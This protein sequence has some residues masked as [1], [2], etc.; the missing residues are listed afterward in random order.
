MTS[1]TSL[2]TDFA[3]AKGI[4]APLL[5][6]TQEVTVNDLPVS[7]VFEGIGEV[8]DLVFYTPLGKIPDE[9]AAQAHR[10]MLE[11]NHLWA[12]TGGAT[13]GLL[14]DGTATLC[15]RTPL[16][17]MNAEVLADTLALFAGQAEN[18]MLLLGTPGAL[19][20]SA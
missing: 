12:A 6:Q 10:S 20:L 14:S 19:D 13:L 7:L 2:L 3:N 17:L 18:W 9:R 4:P 5:L 16:S 15:Y 8:G 11:G 1:L